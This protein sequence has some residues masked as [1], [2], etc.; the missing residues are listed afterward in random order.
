[1]DVQ[2]AAPIPFA[3]GTSLPCFN[4]AAP[5][6][7]TK[8]ATHNDKA[9]RLVNGSGGG[10]GGVTAFST[11]FAA[12]RSTDPYT[13]LIADLALHTHTPAAGVSNFVGDVGT[14]G[15]GAGSTIGRF[16]GTAAG[17]AG[18]GGAHSHGM[19]MQVAYVDMIQINKD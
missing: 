9:L 14:Y 19:Q 5:T 18:G 15:A 6:G 8:Q 11:V 12:S 10:S 7:W 4:A 13:L 3:S 17:P 2:S 16:G 1:M